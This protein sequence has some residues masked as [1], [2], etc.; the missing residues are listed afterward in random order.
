VERGGTRNIPRNSLKCDCVGMSYSDIGHPPR[1]IE[2]GVAHHEHG[3]FLSSGKRPG[4]CTTRGASGAHADHL[5]GDAKYGPALAGPAENSTKNDEVLASGH[6]IAS[7]SRSRP[8]DKHR[9]W[10]LIV[11][12]SPKLYV[13]RRL[14]IIKRSAG[15]VE[16]LAP[17]S[18]LR[19]MPCRTDGGE[20]GVN[21]RRG[22]C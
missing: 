22:L 5:R 8:E 10:H 12:W 6:E 18:P 19:Q 9:I 21:R 20:I 17:T 3:K 11:C 2:A 16:A 14:M 7:K 15:P 1:Q 13:R 4:S